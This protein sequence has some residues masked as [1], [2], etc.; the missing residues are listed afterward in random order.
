MGKKPARS[1]STT[2]LWVK[3]VCGFLGFMM[4]FGILVMVFSSFQSSAIESENSVTVPDQQISVG[5][6]CNENAVQSYALSAENGFKITVGS[7][8][9][10]VSLNSPQIIAT[11]DDNLYRVG[12]DLFTESGGIATVGGYHIE[13]SYFTFADLGIDTDH[14]NPVF[15][16]PGNSI[17]STDGYAPST[18]YEYISLLSEDNTFKA[19]SLYAFPYYP[20]A[21]KCYIRV[22]SFFTRQEAEDV[23]AQLERTITLNARIVEPNN[24]TIS[25]LGQDFSVLCEFYG[26]D[27]D[28]YISTLQNEPMRS[29]SGRS[30]SGTILLK[31]HGVSG[32]Q[33]LNIVNRLS[34]ETYIGILL[35]SEVYSQ[36]NS[37]LLKAMA[38]LLRTEIT[39]KLGS[40][41][42]EGFDICAES[43]CHAYVGGAEVD[44]QILDAVTQTAGQ[45]LT[46][47]GALIYTPYS[48]TVGSG[49]VSSEDAFGTEI[50]YLSGI[51]T[52]WEDLNEWAVEFTPYELYQLLSSCGYSEISGNIASVT[53]SSYAQQSDY[54]NSIT[55]TDLFGNAV[56]VEGSETIRLLFGGKLPSSC[57]VVGMSGETVQR[58]MRKLN[59]NGLEYTESVET[60]TL[61]GTFGSFVFSG[62]GSGCGVGFSVMGA[63]KLADMGLDY[64]QILFTYF[65]EVKISSPNQSE[66]E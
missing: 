65:P 33:R 57:F 64:K 54:V 50:P 46:Y 28:F 47:E 11:V 2:K 5:L 17:G 20:S 19:L 22:G 63:K 59:G 4:V 8:G 9:L 34:L 10:N 51:Y 52:P 31:N 32:R 29:Y 58:P 7:N 60:V 41:S 49:T 27:Q 36:W 42:A 56:T 38:V 25:V 44:Q 62:R 18:I 13:I 39:R 53:V 55:F 6:Y 40:H 61:S 15:I 26:K 66:D 3:I 43:H 35:P 37:E 24:D 21:Q 14:D 48:M 16:R 12:S 30:Y 23:L 45:V 1:D